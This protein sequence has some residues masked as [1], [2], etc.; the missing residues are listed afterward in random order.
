[1]KTDEKEIII[2]DSITSGILKA[3]PASYPDIKLEVTPQ[4]NTETRETTYLIRGDV[5][6]ALQKISK[7]APIGSRDALEAIK[8]MR[9]A[10][11]LYKQ[12]GQR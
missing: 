8:N 11:F 7:N 10:I 9:S 12:G 4:H 2:R 5:D 1:L 3:V 6:E